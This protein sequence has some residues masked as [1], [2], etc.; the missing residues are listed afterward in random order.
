MLWTPVG[1][2]SW[3][4]LFKGSDGYRYMGTAGHCLLESNGEKR[5]ALG[6][7]PVVR[8][9]NNHR[10]GR[11]AYTILRNNYDFALVR[12]D[13][14]V[15]ASASMCHFGGP[16]GLD[17]AHM[18]G[19]VV[20]EHYGNGI[21]VSA[22]TPARTSTALNTLDKKSVVGQ[23]AIAFGDSGSGITRA[24]KA[25]GVIVAVGYQIGGSPLVGDM[26][27]TRIDAQLPRAQKVLGIRLTLQTAKR[28]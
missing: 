28:L 9:N 18:G 15:K 16:T 26:F 11:G 8:D 19:P 3:N 20:L 5:W 7:G 25:L 2:C 12:L 17:T 22:L 14:S 4:F 13:R 23:G 27:V 24:G 1:G 10:V 21:G 6:K